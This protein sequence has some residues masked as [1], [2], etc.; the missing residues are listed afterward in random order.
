MEL[1]FECD[2][3]GAELDELYEPCDVCNGCDECDKGKG[4]EG[5]KPHLQRVEDK[6]RDG[7]HGRG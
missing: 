2:H 7:E 4:R 5:N 6:R 1:W 3:C